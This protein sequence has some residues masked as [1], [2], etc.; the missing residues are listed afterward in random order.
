MSPAAGL[1]YLQYQ[2]EGRDEWA[3]R[4][5]AADSKPLLFIAPL[6]E[7]MNRTRA[8]LAA[9]MRG[10]AARGFACWLPDLPGTGESLRKLGECGWDSWRGAVAALSADL[11]GPP[12]VALRGG[13]LL[14]DAARPRFRYRISPV[15]G[16]SLVRDLGRSAIMG[17]GEG[18]AGY[19]P[20]DELLASLSQATPASGR[21]IRTAR[22]A[23]DRGEADVKFEGPALWRRS[24]PATNPL[25]SSMLAEDIANWAQQCAA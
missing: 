2:C 7:E 5:G 24:E 10:V 23:S 15:D 1:A 25:F 8:F 16:S 4:I 19:E 21:A 13:C 3:V 6:F 22:L 11:G 12:T 20:S 9:S 14:D 17:G 18:L